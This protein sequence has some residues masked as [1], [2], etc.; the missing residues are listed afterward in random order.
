M[1]SEPMKEPQYEEMR[2]AEQSF[3]RAT[4]GLSTNQA[5]LQDPKTLVFRSAC[6]KFVAHM[7]RGKQRVLEV[8]CGDAFMS[9]IVQQEVGNLIA[10]DF[11]PVLINDALERT[12][13]PWPIDLRV[14]DFLDG[15]ILEEFDAAYSLDVLEHIQ[16]TEAPRF[17]ENVCRSLARG[18]VAVFGMPS[19]ES[20]AYA[21]WGSRIG[22]VNC[23]SGA[24]SVAFLSG[25]FEQVFLFSAND[26]VVHTGFS[27]MAHYLICLCVAPKSL[28]VR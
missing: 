10:V 13:D 1:K 25:F 19:I 26:E 12:I 24:D 23:M 14:H 27:K 28:E 8:G 11:D 15:P 7:L 5:Y 18:G 17:V 21:S 3:G 4:L 20:Q 16:P 6:Y 2:K 9:R 22:H